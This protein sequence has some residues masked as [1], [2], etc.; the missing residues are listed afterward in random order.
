MERIAIAKAREDQERRDQ[1][2][3]TST[4]DLVQSIAGAFVE[5]D[6]D[7]SPASVA[8]GIRTAFEE[9]IAAGLLEGEPPSLETI[10]KALKHG[11]RE[12]YSEVVFEPEETEQDEAVTRAGR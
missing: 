10:T 8:V 3:A 7:I 5:N 4:Q 9:M 1:L 6:R 2:F 12:T 11:S